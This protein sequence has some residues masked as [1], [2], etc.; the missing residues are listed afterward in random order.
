MTFKRLFLVI[1]AIPKVD[2]PFWVI[3][4][5]IPGPPL[6]ISEFFTPT[7]SKIK[8]PDDRAGPGTAR[9]FRSAKVMQIRRLCLSLPRGFWREKKD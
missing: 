5:Q 6:K 7:E 1:C 8:V 3:L 2:R 9:Y 4:R